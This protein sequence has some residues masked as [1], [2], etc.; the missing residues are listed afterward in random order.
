MHANLVRL[1]IEKFNSKKTLFHSNYVHAVSNW[2]LNDAQEKEL[3][4]ACLSYPQLQHIHFLKF[5]DN[6]VQILLGVDN[7]QLIL[8]REF[9]QRLSESPF[10][11]HNLLGWTITCPIKRNIEPIP[12]ETNFLSHSYIAFDYALTSLIVDTERHLNDCVTSLLK[13]ENTGTQFK[14][15]ADP[16]TD[17]KRAVQ[18]L[19]KIIRLIGDRKKNWFSLETGQ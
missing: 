16:S 14:E 9:L 19:Q 6:K 2:T 17:S 13:I 12:E 11:L 15:T 7:T 1:D 10:A 8:E 5:I 3:N 18:I 4:K